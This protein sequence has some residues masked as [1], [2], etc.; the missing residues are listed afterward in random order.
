M[1]R[2]GNMAFPVDCAAFLNANQCFQVSVALSSNLET[3][4]FF[5]HSN[6]APR[7][8]TAALYI[9]TQHSLA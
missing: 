5:K 1:T 4:E 8:K 6:T 2:L 3:L 7:M 9:L